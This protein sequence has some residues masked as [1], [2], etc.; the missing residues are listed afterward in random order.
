MQDGLTALSRG[1]KKW[2]GWKRVGVAARRTPAARR[3]APRP[4]R[5]TGPAREP[6]RRWSS[7]SGEPAICRMPVIPFA[8]ISANAPDA[9][10]CWS[11]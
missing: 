9:S 4:A 5:T 7:N 11:E 2:I 8:S 6:R 1:F 10:G 3:H